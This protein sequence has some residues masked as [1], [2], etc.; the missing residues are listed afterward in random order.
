MPPNP[1]L[2]SSKLHLTRNLETC[3]IC[4]QS[5]YLN[6]HMRFLVNP[7]CYHKMCSSC[8]D[9]I[10][11]AG[12]A[13]CP[14]AGCHRTLRKARFRPQTFDDI[15][16]ERE[17]DI[18]RRISAVFNRRQEEFETLR[19]WNN[20]LEDVET[21]TYNLLT[22]VEVEETEQ[23]LREYARAN[24]EVISSNAKKESSEHASVEALQEAER[25]RARL[26]REAAR[27]EEVEDRRQKEEGRREVISRLASGEGGDAEAIAREGQRVV[28]KRSTARRTAEERQ[29]QLL[30]EQQNQKA[31][32]ASGSLNGGAA[33]ADNGSSFVIK[34]LKQAVV[35][36]PE[37]PY[38]AFGGY[39]DER[40]YVVLQDYYD[41]PWLEEVRS[42]PQYS[43]GGYDVHEYYARAL[44]DAFSGLGC[45]IGEEMAAKDKAAPLPIATAA[46]ASAAGGDGDMTMEQA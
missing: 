4:K 44:F 30:L 34:G 32:L 36:E 29:R 9:R 20:Y 6:P 14:V 40:E 46:A 19:D 12:P 43:A 41:H 18:R 2:V 13:P 23:K 28:L 45:F 37:K 33:G 26:R 39:T 15:N 38:D 17:V 42:K 16:I 21:L 1:I 27:R 3:P 25:E 22:G 10:F 31:T 8:V 5:R 35:A 24:R 7:E 11:S